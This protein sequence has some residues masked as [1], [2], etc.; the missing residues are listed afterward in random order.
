[1]QVSLIAAIGQNRV[2]GIGNKL[3]WHIP[4][5]L[6]RFKQLTLG[7]P[8]IMGR[9]TWESIGKPLPHRVNIILTG[10]KDWQLASAEIA[11]D[12]DEALTLA[13]STC[14]EQTEA[15]VIG[16]EQIYRLFL[17]HAT[18]LYLTEVDSSVEGD[19]FF[20]EIDFSMWRPVS[21]GDWMTSGTW[22]YRFLLYERSPA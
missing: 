7:K 11:H 6:R 3:P 2:I 8:V 20:P 9:K 21:I 15:M 16:G 14:G 5:D 12:I 19:T 10:R 4:E 17:P 18:R 22:R 1:M 13:R